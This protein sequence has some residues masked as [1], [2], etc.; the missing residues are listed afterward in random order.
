VAGSSRFLDGYRRLLERATAR[1]GIAVLALVP[2]AI[3][4]ALAFNTLPSGFMPRQ[5]EGGFI[6]DYITPPGTSLAESDRLIRQIE[7][8]LSSTPEVVTYSRR[9]GAQLGGALTEPNVGDFFVRLKKPP[10]RGIEAVMNDVRDR[11]RARVPGVDIETAQ[12]IE[13]LI[14]DLT[15]VPQPIEVK[16]YGEDQAQLQATAAQVAARVEAVRGLT[17]VRDGVVVAGDALDVRLDLARAALEGVAPA[18]ASKQIGALLGGQ[19]A[20]QVQ[21]GP[22]LTDVRVWIPQAERGQ[23]GDIAGLPLRAADGHIFDL[24]RIATVET[25]TGQA[26]I[27]REGG[28]RMVPVTARVV[29]RDLGGAAA[30]IQRQLAAPGVLPA[31][32][33][34]EMGCLYAE[35]QS[36]FRGL[37]TVFV[38]AL[39][40]V[41]VLLLLLYENFRIVGAIVAMPLAAACAVAGGLWIAGVELDI[42]ALM[43]L[44]MVIGIVT[45]VAIFYFTEYDGLIAEGVAPR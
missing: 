36:A 40:I 7:A 18:E 45:E 21:A 12:L 33:T 25:L 35:Q 41:T 43:G 13:D 27:E 23:V 10:R 16:L 20:T 30:E 2:L 14:G 5:D 19:V 34:F 37:A 26:E 1:P 38:A 3:A 22:F 4:G 6:L 42:M 44:T 31:G 11:V 32:I 17:E 24:S 15:S 9:T 8:I 39:G 28:R 29:G